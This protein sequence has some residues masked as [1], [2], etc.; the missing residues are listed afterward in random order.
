MRKARAL[1]SRTIGIRYAWVALAM[2]FASAQAEPQDAA[3]EVELVSSV[4]WQPLSESSFDQSGD[5][6]AA[7]VYPPGIPVVLRRASTHRR[8]RIEQYFNQPIAPDSLVPRVL[9]TWAR[10]A[11][12]L[13]YDGQAGEWRNAY[14]TLTKPVCAAAAGLGY[15][16]VLDMTIGRSM[17]TGTV[18]ISVGLVVR[19]IEFTH[20]NAIFWVILPEE[21]AADSKALASV[22]PAVDRPWVDGPASWG[23]LPTG[24]DLSRVERHV[25]RITLAGNF[26]LGSGFLV[27]SVRPFAK[28]F[29]PRVLDALEAGDDPS[30]S[31]LF[32]VTAAHLFPVGYSYGAMPDPLADGIGDADTRPLRLGYIFDLQVDGALLPGAALLVARNVESDVALLEVRRHSLKKL[33]S[34]LRAGDGS[35][36]IGLELAPEFGDRLTPKDRFWVLGYPARLTGERVRRGAKVAPQGYAT[37][38]T[39][40]FGPITKVKLEPSLV[41]GEALPMPDGRLLAEPGMSG[42]PV[43]N[44][45]GLVVG[46]AVERPN[47]SNSLIALDLTSVATLVHGFALEEGRCMLRFN[48]FDRILTLVHRD[49]D[50]DYGHFGSRLAFSPLMGARTIQE[51]QGFADEASVTLESAG[52]R[53]QPTNGHSIINGHAVINGH[54]IINGH[55]IIR[56]SVVVVT[57]DNLDAVNSGELNSGFRL[58]PDSFRS[59]VPKG[60]RILDDQESAEGLPLGDLILGTRDRQDEDTFR[61]LYSIRDFVIWLHRHENRGKGYL[62]LLCISGHCGGP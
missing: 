53:Q 8:F 49:D 27:R 61:P 44:S 5:A 24:F 50:C 60:V 11:N 47:D 15:R 34:M 38:D 25:A 51:V 17:P 54:T 19:G 36:S 59:F 56:S 20:P 33:E 10:S 43:V 55:S 6:G 57:R 41:A 21:A 2:G 46:M 37:E 62:Q 31:R 35:A 3:G 18:G 42:G 14:M 58:N 9:G 12:E 39:S 16:C 45:S 4:I 29:K 7:Y 23:S 40:N 30:D 1:I 48:P 32:V 28:L 13:S 26:S 52:G 22:V